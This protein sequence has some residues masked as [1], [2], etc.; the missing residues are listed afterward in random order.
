MKARGTTIIKA[1]KSRNHTELLCKYL[2]LPILI[3]HKKDY[4]EITVKQIKKIKTL[5]YNIPADISSSA[6]FIGLTVLSPNSKLIIKNVNINPSRTG[7]ITILRK[8]GVSI[9]FKN[10][11]IYKGEKKANIIIKSAK[12]LKAIDCPPKLNSGAID[13]FLVIFL[14]AAKA[15]GISFFK[16]L[17]ELNQK[18]SPRLEW[19]QKILNK[20][21]IK[22]ITNK[23]SI[24]IF[25]NPR[26]EIKHRYGPGGMLFEGNAGGTRRNSNVASWLRV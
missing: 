14:I 7:M 22:T 13:E 20:M 2:G 4:D 18:E 12:K 25:G 8:M 16:N 10:E 26:L 5:N 15:E 17:N 6:F 24:K 1:K 23:N 9:D 21:G 11:K 19:A 3:K